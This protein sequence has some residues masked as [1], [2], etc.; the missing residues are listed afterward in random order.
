MALKIDP[1]FF[2]VIFPVAITMLALFKLVAGLGQVTRK[3][4][5]AKITITAE[6]AA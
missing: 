3:G 5:A 6:L 4:W 1:Q 2:R